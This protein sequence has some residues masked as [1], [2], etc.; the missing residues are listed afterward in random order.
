MVI[1]TSRPRL[2]HFPD[3]LGKRLELGQVGADFMRVPGVALRGANL[4]WLR[5]PSVAGSWRQAHLRASRY[6]GQPPLVGLPTVAR[7][8][9]VKR[10][11]RLVDLTGIEPVTS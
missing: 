6:G 8:P 9:V 5:S 10:E 1:R 7:A 2:G 3:A 4:R 11:R